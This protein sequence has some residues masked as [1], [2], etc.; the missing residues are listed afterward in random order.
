[1][2][3]SNKIARFPVEHMAFP[4]TNFRHVAAKITKT[5]LLQGKRPHKK[6]Q[7]NKHADNVVHDP[8]HKISAKMFA[9]QLTVQQFLLPAAAKNIIVSGSGQM[10]Y[11]AAN[12]R[13]PRFVV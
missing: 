10:I 3:R 4:P 7:P 13:E 9:L 11:S 8:F 2:S 1:M 12:I 6:Y 5:L